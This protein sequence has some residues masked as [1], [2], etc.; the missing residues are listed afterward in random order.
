MFGSPPKVRPGDAAPAFDLPA[1]DGRQIKLVALRGKKRVVLA[2]YP[3]DD[4]AGCQAELTRFQTSLGRFIELK[5][6]VMAVSH[7]LST[8]QARFAEKLA[9]QFPLLSDPKGLIAKSYGAKGILPYFDRK[10]FVIDGRGVL[11]LVQNGQPNIDQLIV[12]LDGLRGDVEAT[13]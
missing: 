4:T 8:S 12:F 3:E 1:H 5:T 7:N 2:F 9:L 6:Q 11:R 10:T 13:S